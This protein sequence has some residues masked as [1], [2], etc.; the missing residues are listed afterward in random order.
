MHRS[1]CSPPGQIR[2]SSSGFGLFPVQRSSESGKVTLEGVINTLAMIAVWIQARLGLIRVN[3]FAHQKPVTW[4]AVFNEGFKG[5][6]AQLFRPEIGRASCRER[7][8]IAV[9]AV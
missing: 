9:L 2:A 8:A 6:G 3:G 5:P 4:L 1:Y 7:V